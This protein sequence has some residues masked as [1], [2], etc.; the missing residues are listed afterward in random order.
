MQRLETLRYAE[1]LTPRR[2][3]RW[4]CAFLLLSAIVVT[5]HVVSHTAM[6]LTNRSG[7]QLG[8]D[9]INYWSGAR[10]ADRGQAALAYDF[11]FYDSFQKAVMGAAA[12]AKIYGYP[13]I[14]MMLS[15]PLAT[16]GFVWALVAWT[17][18]GAAFCLLMLS[19]SFDW[20]WAALGTFSAPAALL[21][22]LTGQNGYFSAG[23]LGGGLTILERRPILAGLMFGLLSYKPHL[24]VLLPV[25]LVAGGYWRAAVVA[26]ATVALLVLVSGLLLGVDAWIAFGHQMRVQRLVMETAAGAWHRMPTVFVALRMAGIGAKAAYAAQIASAVA[27]AAVVAVVWRSRSA[28]PIK[29][30]A[31]LVATFLA[32]P[33]AQDYDMVMLIFAVAWLTTEAG[34]DGF[35][36]WERITAASLLVLPLMA[37]ALAQATGVQIGPPV[38]WAM[39]VLLARRALA[40]SARADRFT[41]PAVAPSSARL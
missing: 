5:A 38:L 37:S 35:R 27:A 16:L 39:L 41:S 8:I 31:M 6:G 1:W 12:D 24:G 15:W 13:P 26:T 19:R 30:A 10:F 20:R 36:P 14:A 32:T 11:L 18:V 17:A 29:A 25:A 7:E 2:A 34:R 33:Y 28:Y 21:N 23:L 40:S 3:L 4:S 22:I 9:F